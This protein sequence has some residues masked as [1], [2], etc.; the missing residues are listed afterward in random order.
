MLINEGRQQQAEG[1]GAENA[2]ARKRLQWKARH[3]EARDYIRWRRR[4]ESDWHVRLVTEQPGQT[5]LCGEAVDG[6][7]EIENTGAEVVAVRGVVERQGGSPDPKKRIGIRAERIGPTLGPGQWTCWRARGEKVVVR[8]ARECRLMNRVDYLDILREQSV[9]ERRT[10]EASMLM[11]DMLRWPGEQLAVQTM[12]SATARGIDG[13]KEGET[14]PQS[15]EEA[16]QAAE[17]EAGY[18]PSLVVGIA[19]CE[20]EAGTGEEELAEEIGALL[21][22]EEPPVSARVRA[23][24]ALTFR[25]CEP[26]DGAGFQDGRPAAALCDSEHIACSLRVWLNPRTE[27]GP[28]LR[29][30]RTADPEAEEK[31]RQGPNCIVHELRKTEPGAPRAMRWATAR[32]EGSREVEGMSAAAGGR[33]RLFAAGGSERDVEDAIAE[34]MVEGK[35]RGWERNEGWTSAHVTHEGC[36]LQESRAQYVSRKPAARGLPKNPAM[37]AGTATSAARVLE[38][39]RDSVPYDK[40]TRD[41]GRGSLPVRNPDAIVGAA[42]AWGRLVLL[43]ERNLPELPPD[44]KHLRRWRS[45]PCAAPMLVGAD[46]A[47]ENPKGIEIRRVMA[48]LECGLTWQ[49]LAA[50]WNIDEQAV[51]AAIQYTIDAIGKERDLPK[52]E[53]AGPPTNTE[54]AERPERA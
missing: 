23:V 17:R 50:E 20:E 37:I 29:A 16:L 11:A 36:L 5:P 22:A 28:S 51:R 7:I 34:R 54:Q 48:G 27:P 19:A 4:G 35:G 30:W 41:A 24:A 2:G 9:G 40:I 47:R 38:R 31:L 26:V 49:E 42:A 44:A 46:P 53:D 6:W 21:A 32:Q 13:T 52:P 12:S 25:A 15:V 45:L 1:A 8:T 10:F 3:P 43:D 14:R 39:V 33:T 18:G